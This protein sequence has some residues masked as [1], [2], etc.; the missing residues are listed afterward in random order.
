MAGGNESSR[1]FRCCRTGTDRAPRQRTLSSP[2]LRRSEHGSIFKIIQKDLDHLSTMAGTENA[3]AV[4]VGAVCLGAVFER[5]H[6]AFVPEFQLYRPISAVGRRIINQQEIV[7][8]S[9]N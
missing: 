7:H 8:L 3:K 2:P 4:E 1:P 5:Q 6:R 9:R